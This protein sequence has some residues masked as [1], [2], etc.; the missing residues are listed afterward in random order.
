MTID[1]NIDSWLEDF[2]TK[3]VEKFGNRLSFF[4]IQGSY[5]RGE[6][7]AGSD[8]DVVVIID[9]ITHYDLL[10]YRNMIDTMNFSNKICG[11]VSGVDVLRAWNKSDLLQLFLDTQPIVGSLD[12]FGISFT[13]EDIRNAVRI[14]ACNLYHVC[15]HNLLHARSMDTL[16]RL[17][18]TARFIVR[19]KYYYI[20]ENYIAKF[21]DLEDIVPGADRLVLK[22]AG[23]IGDRCNDD[24]FDRYSMILLDWVGDVIKLMWQVLP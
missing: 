1:F 21:S 15:S 22:L 6:Q 17:Y 8:I 16:M 13:K 24:D 19:M 20:T 11:F 12:S 2:K 18:K 23:E 9:G 3:L 10:A 14:E 7:T 4:G 5:G